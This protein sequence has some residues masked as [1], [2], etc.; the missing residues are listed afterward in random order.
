MRCVLQALTRSLPVR[1]HSRTRWWV[2]VEMR[3]PSQG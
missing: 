3:A 1:I 2:T